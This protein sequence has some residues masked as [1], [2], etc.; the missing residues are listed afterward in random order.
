MSK[1]QKTSPHFLHATV[2]LFILVW[3]GTAS[4]GEPAPSCDRLAEKITGDQ[5]RLS[6]EAQVN[7]FAAFTDIACAM[8]YRDKNFCAMETMSFDST[9]RVF[10]FISGAEIEMSTAFFV[11]ES[12]KTPLPMIQ[13]FKT[14]EDALRQADGHPERK[15]ATYSELAA[16]RLR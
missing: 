5:A 8:I 10:D 2:L 9:A 1:L 7:G 13:A 12:G 15:V 11:V 6:V 3:I 4:A 16:I 14:K